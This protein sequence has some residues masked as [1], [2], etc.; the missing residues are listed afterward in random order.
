MQIFDKQEAWYNVPAASLS[1][2][3]IRDQ[4]A[5]LAIEVLEKEGKL[6]KGPKSKEHGEFRSSIGVRE[7]EGGSKNGGTEVFDA[8]KHTSE[9]LFLNGPLS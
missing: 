7:K 1:A 6:G 3:Q 2:D 5:D 8:F 9:S 4:L